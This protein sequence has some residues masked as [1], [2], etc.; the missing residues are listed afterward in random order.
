VPTQ[1][2]TNFFD[3]THQVLADQVKQYSQSGRELENG[4]AIYKVDL[5]TPNSYKVDFSSG[6]Q[7]DGPLPN[8]GQ[9]VY[10]KAKNTNTD[11]STL[12]IISPSGE[13]PPIPLVKEGN[14]PLNSGDISAD[15]AVSLIYLEDDGGG[16][17]RFE[18]LGAVTPG[19]QV[20][21]IVSSY[22]PAISGHLEANGQILSQVDYPELFSQIGSLPQLPADNSPPF[23]W[24]EKIAPPTP[25]Y[26]T[27]YTFFW[28]QGQWYA[29]GSSG[30]LVTSLDGVNWTH[31]ATLG[32]SG[33]TGLAHGNG[34]FVAVTDSGKI[35]TSPN[36][37]S[38][39]LR[40]TPSTQARKCVAYGNGRFIAGGS[41]SQ[42]L[43]SSLNGITWSVIAAPNSDEIR[44][45]IYANGQF[46][47]VGSYSTVRLA[48]WTSPDGITWTNRPASGSGAI[49]GVAYG[50]GIYLAVASNGRV[51]TSPDAITWA[52]QLVGS[53]ASYSVVFGNG[54]FLFSSFAISVDGKNSAS[55][56]RPSQS[57]A[58]GGVG[59]G[60][61]TF[62]AGV[63][64]S[65]MWTSLG[66]PSLT[67]DPATEFRLPSIDPP[68]PGMKTFIKAR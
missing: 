51:W 54:V 63:Q 2:T 65:R 31:I 47:A 36:A 30:L 58:V 49:S 5:G 41:S 52:D 38:W 37:Y 39:T 18:I 17:G 12:T 10:F 1:F 40:T 8:V 64:Y 66:A 13:L 32:T 43:W 23:T 14:R 16:N 55:L 57:Y 67:Y 42:P 34:L 61:G 28:H 59:F 35:Y 15:Q 45:I 6:N 62:V 9:M 60:N 25:N 11:P 26:G 7:I 33:I 4:Q 53:L 21:D 24:T 29:A 22:R 56:I 68:A 50:N 20:G 44:D 3:L 27:Y 48:L 46:V 19:G